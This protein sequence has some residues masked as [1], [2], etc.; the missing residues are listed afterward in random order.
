MTR[1]FEGVRI[2]DTTHVLAGPFAT[3]QLA[4]LG[5]D[6][7]KIEHP[8]WPDQTRHMGPDRKLGRDLMGTGYLN[9]ASNKRA[10][11]LDLKSEEGR[12]ILKALVKDADVFVENYRTEAFPSLGLGYEDLKAINPKLI[13]CS[14][15]AWGD[16]GPRANQTGYDQ[17]IQGYAGVMS[18][19]GSPETGPLRCGPQLLDF[20]AGTTAAFALA[21]ALFR[22]ERTGEGQHITGCLTDTAFV[23]MSAQMTGF[24]RTGR[25]LGYQTTDRGHAGQSR[26][27]TKDGGHVVLGAGNDRQYTRFWEAI[28]H[29]EHGGK[30]HAARSDSSAEE[31][32]IIAEI[33]LTKTAQEWEDYL[34]SNHVPAARLRTV[35]EAVEDPQAEHRRTFHRFEQGCPGVDGPFSVPIAAFDCNDD[36]PRVDAPP[37]R[38]GEHTEDILAGLGYSGDQIADLRERKVI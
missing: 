34:Q 15:T 2:I 5:A 6:V 11:T 13:Y 19:T 36:G 38:M 25:E 32:A 1:A 30:D 33:M 24:L 35:K 10:M 9:Q 14:L 37:P 23:L 27:K 18:I 29:P 31:R 26:Y 21:S 12:E 20:G 22:R 17:V 16:K 3:Y 8:D 7:I 4:L 28:G